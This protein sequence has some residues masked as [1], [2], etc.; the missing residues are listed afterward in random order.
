MLEAYVFVHL[1]LIGPESVT[2]LESVMALSTSAK[3]RLDVVAS[4]GREVISRDE[5]FFQHNI[6]LL[7]DPAEVVFSKGEVVAG[8]YFGNSR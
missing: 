4:I 5:F 3:M 2:T 6:T 7:E 1:Q 8:A